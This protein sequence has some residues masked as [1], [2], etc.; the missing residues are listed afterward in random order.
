[1]AQEH[2]DNKLHPFIV[3]HQRKVPRSPNYVQFQQTS[4]SYQPQSVPY[5]FNKC[6]LP[7]R[8]PRPKYQSLRLPQSFETLQNHNSIFPKPN[9]LNIPRK[10]L[11]HPN[12]SSLPRMPSSTID[13]DQ[14]HSIDPMPIIL[15][16]SVRMERKFDKKS[17]VESLV[18][19]IIN[20]IKSEKSIAMSQETTAFARDYY[21]NIVNNCNKSFRQK[22]DQIYNDLVKGTSGYIS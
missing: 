15:N 17:C 13:D 12:R 21:L 9:N 1:M 6:L 22:K 18:G 8:L 14:S 7:K 10:H 20:S 19:T 3:D 5:N 2:N 16:K 4:N 11:S